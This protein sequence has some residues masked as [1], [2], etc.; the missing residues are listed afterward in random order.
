MDEASKAR[1]NLSRRSL[2]IASGLPKPGPTSGPWVVRAKRDEPRT[3]MESSMKRAAPRR[4][5]RNFWPGIGSPTGS[6]S[7]PT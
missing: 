6:V 1:R 2:P 4:G 3:A 5:A 7:P